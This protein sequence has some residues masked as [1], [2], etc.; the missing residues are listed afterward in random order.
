MGGHGLGASSRVRKPVGAARFRE[1]VVEP[2]MYRVV[3]N[4]APPPG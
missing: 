2:G 3:L 4:E 1:A